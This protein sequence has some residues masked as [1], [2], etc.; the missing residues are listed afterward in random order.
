MVGGEDLMLKSKS[1][2]PNFYTV[3]KRRIEKNRMCI[4]Y[5]LHNLRKPRQYWIVIL[6]L[7]VQNFKKCKKIKYQKSEKV[8][9]ILFDSKAEIKSECFDF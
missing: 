5:K 2:G 8:S 6:Q 1:N 9:F 4:T 3:K 7:V